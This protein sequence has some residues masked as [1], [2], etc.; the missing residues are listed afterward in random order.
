MIPKSHPPFPLLALLAREDRNGW[1]NGVQ[2]FMKLHIDF[3]YK[4]NRD[5]DTRS[6]LN[7]TF[8]RVKNSENF[9]SNL[10]KGAKSLS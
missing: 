6:L 5:V 7:F 4:P 9:T 3:R 8:L 1:Q 10:K 2:Y